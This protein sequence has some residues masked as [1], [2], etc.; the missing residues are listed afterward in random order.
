MAERRYIPLTSLSADPH[1]CTPDV[2]LTRLGQA[3]LFADLMP[4][5][6]ASVD[7]RCHVQGF[8]SGEPIYHAGDAARRIFVVA[9]GMVKTIRTSMDGRETLLDLCGPGDF[10]GAVP[11]LGQERHSESAWT[12]TPT[13]LLTLDAR[14]YDAVMKEHPVVALAALADLA[15]RLEE[16]QESVHRLSVASLDQRLAAVLILLAEKVGEPWGEAVL[17]QVP[18]TREDLAAMTG[19][20]TESVSRLLSNWRRDGLIETGRRWIA[21]RD[22]DSLASL[23]AGTTASI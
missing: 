9:T 1:T 13:C 11:A 21:L 22:R 6:L 2:R 18:L 20:A 15:R 14:E 10:F 5:Q 7:E 12:L 17:L 8:S 3:V 4:E 19:A 16:S 23:A